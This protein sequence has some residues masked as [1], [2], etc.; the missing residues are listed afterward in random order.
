MPPVSEQWWYWTYLQNIP[1]TFPGFN[2]LGPV[3]FWSLAVEEHFYLV[4]PA[5]VW[6]TPTR[7]LPRVSIGLILAAVAIRAL[8]LSHGLGMFTSYSLPNGRPC[9]G[10]SSRHNR[11]GDY[12]QAENGRNPLARSDHD[13][14]YPVGLIA[15]HNRPRAGYVFTVIGFF[16]FSLI[17]Y[18]LSH[19]QSRMVRLL[20]SRPLVFS[21]TISYGLYVYHPACVEFCKT[22]PDM[23]AICQHRLEFHR[24]NGQLLW[25]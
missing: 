24:S 17:A 22:L 20:S 4:W 16:Y 18:V 8:M 14:R 5:L 11:S 7:I 6:M 19:E 21:G 9:V 23:L 13:S 2:A 1:A 10:H 15:F 12:Y 25:I 3:H